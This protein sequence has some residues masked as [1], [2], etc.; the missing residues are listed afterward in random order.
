MSRKK[1]GKNCATARKSDGEIC[2]TIGHAKFFQSTF[3]MLT[4]PPL[5]HKT[6][7]WHSC[8]TPLFHGQPNDALSITAHHRVSLLVPH[9][10][11]HVVLCLR[12][13]H[14][15]ASVDNLSRPVLDCAAASCTIQSINQFN[16]RAACCL[17]LP[18]CALAPLP[19]T[20]PPASYALSSPAVP[21][22]PTT[23]HHLLFPTTHKGTTPRNLC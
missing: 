21:R 7:P 13:C 8:P 2:A 1:Y 6:S 5:Y 12:F 4:P 20:P 22:T 16:S 14:R 10:S 18:G 15:G 23:K 3:P 19:P 11:H 9:P 17:L